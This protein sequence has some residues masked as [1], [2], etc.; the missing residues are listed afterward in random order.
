MT[1]NQFQAL[2]NKHIEE[3]IIMNVKDLSILFKHVNFEDDKDVKNQMLQIIQQY[4]GKAESHNGNEVL[5]VATEASP[6]IENVE[7]VSVEEKV[8]EPESAQGQTEEV[9]VVPS[10][11]PETAV[12]ADQEDVSLK[13][14]EKV[15]PIKKNITG[16]E[17][18]EAAL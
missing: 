12:E 18:I 7:E 13:E 8:V 14:A 15:S 9:A 2:M 16:V 5:S 1:T 6:A 11:E 10:V 4:L 3:R 17:D